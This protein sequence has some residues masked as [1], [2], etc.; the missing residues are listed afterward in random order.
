PSH[1]AGH[2]TPPPPSAA[3]RTTP[4]P[5]RSARYRSWRRS[6]SHCRHSA[7]GSA[8]Q[9]PVGLLLELVSSAESP[10]PLWERD[11]V[12]G[13]APAGAEEPVNGKH[14]GNLNAK[15]F[16]A[17][18]RGPSPCPSPTRGEGD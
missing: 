18:A 14:S 5:P 16:R 15:S 10:L 8:W 1:R 2:R 3:P 17:A 12:R 11:R 13:P 4:H 9:P 7:L 6:L